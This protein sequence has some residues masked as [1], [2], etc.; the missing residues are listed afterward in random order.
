MMIVGLVGVFALGSWVLARP[1]NG[2]AGELS[3]RELPLSHPWNAAR[4]ARF[5]TPEAQN[6]WIEGSAAFIDVLPNFPPPPDLPPGTLWRGQQRFNILGSTWLPDTGYGLLSASAEDY[7]RPE[8]S[9]TRN[10]TP[11]CSGLWPQHYVL[12]FRSE[13][14]TREE[15]S[16]CWA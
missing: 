4:S 10:E 14:Q 8:A 9:I 3:Q 7:L 13:A 11:Q 2:R 5:T 15:E 16:L 12:P 1:L 6:L